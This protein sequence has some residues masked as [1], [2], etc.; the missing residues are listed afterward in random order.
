MR[1]D[2]AAAKKQRLEAPPAAAQNGPPPA[3]QLNQLK[4]PFDEDG[5]D[6]SKR[7]RHMPPEEEDG[8]GGADWC[9]NRP[10]ALLQASFWLTGGALRRDAGLE[11]IVRR[12][13][14]RSSK[15]VTAFDPVAEAA[16]PQWNDGA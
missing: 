14:G 9:A 2:Q 1:A 16:K 11:G 7:L 10:R 5:G 15:P 12:A 8:G 3:G 4:R 13:S 6:P